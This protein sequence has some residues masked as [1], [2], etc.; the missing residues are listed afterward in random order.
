MTRLALES[1]VFAHGLPAPTG[2]DTAL[3]LETIVRNAGVEPRTIGI[4]SGEVVVG[5]TESQI[6]L[7]AN[8]D[9][10]RKASLRDL[11]AVLAAQAHAAT[12]VASTAFL[13]HR[14]G[15]R[16]M[17]TGGIGGVHRST[18]GAAHADVSN[19]LTVL[20]NTPITVVCSG[21]K[22]ILDLPATLEWLETTGVTV[23]GYQTDELP[24][25]YSRNTGL[26]VDIRCDTPDDVSEIVRARDELGMSSAVL[27][28]VPCPPESEVPAEV[29]K[30]QIDAAI[31]V[32]GDSGISSG[33]LTPFLLNR[34]AESTDGQSLRAN[35]SLLKHN[36]SV[37]SEIASKLDE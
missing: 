25:F 28:C 18:H 20:A 12:T 1:T 27:V 24:A 34:I 17:C 14:A 36:A 37:A 8:D 7:L 22:A 21:A 3:A 11:P 31:Q 4:V 13:A 32:A 19:D 2:V 6:R 5:L 30:I 35:I 23:I 26:G 16:V 29:L 33:A 9:G 10:V 15:I